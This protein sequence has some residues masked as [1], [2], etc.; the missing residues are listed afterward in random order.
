MHHVTSLQGNE[1]KLLLATH[2]FQFTQVPGDVVSLDV[3]RA[4]K[5]EYIEGIRTPVKE[6]LGAFFGLCHDCRVCRVQFFFSVILLRDAKNFVRAARL[7][8][9]DKPDTPAGVAHLSRVIKTT[10][11]LHFRRT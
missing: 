8:T 7:K 4:Q 11:N 3:R 9:A 1:D 2:G 6:L 5:Q 10:N